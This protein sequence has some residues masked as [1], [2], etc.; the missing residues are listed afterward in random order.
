MILHFSQMMVSKWEFMFWA[1]FS[2]LNNHFPF[3]FLDPRSVLH[4]FLRPT[5][6]EWKNKLKGIQK[7]TW[8]RGRIETMPSGERAGWQGSRGG[9]P[10]QTFVMRKEDSICDHWGGRGWNYGDCWLVVST[11][12]SLVW[13]KLHGRERDLKTQSC[14]HLW[15][16]YPAGLQGLRSHPYLGWSHVP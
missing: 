6:W 15:S 3:A 1:A 16:Y 4:S 7:S 14:S 5:H 12:S 2:L 11:Y 13:G 8:G 10:P 9:F